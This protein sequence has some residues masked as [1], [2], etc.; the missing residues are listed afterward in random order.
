MK[1]TALLFFISAMIFS[2][3]NYNF[4]GKLNYYYIN[5]LSDG[6]IINLPFRIADFIFQKENGD[7]SIYANMAMEYRLPSDNHFLVNT[8]S[9]DFTWDL[10]ELYLSW[11]I[12]FGEIRI[13]KQ[14]AITCWPSRASAKQFSTP[15]LPAN[16]RISLPVVASHWRPVLSTPTLINDLPSDAKATAVAPPSWPTIMLSRLNRR[17]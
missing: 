13:G 16:V 7:F 17:T 8:S 14:T 2:Q 12:P 10:R 6:S 9:Q 3:E 11:Y 4:S 5:R 1:K 15:L